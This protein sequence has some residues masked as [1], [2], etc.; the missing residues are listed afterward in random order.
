MCYSKNKNRLRCAMTLTEMIIAMA[1]IVVI[2]TAL[3]PQIRSIQNSWSSKRGNAETIQTARV[4]IDHFSYNLAKAKQ[5]TSVSASTEMNGHIEFIDNNDITMRYDIDNSYVRFGQTDDLYEIAGPV[6][7]LVFTCYAMDDLDNAITEVNDIRVVSIQTT[8]TNS[9]A[10]GEDKTFTSSAYLRTNWNSQLQGLQGWYTLDETS[11]TDAADFSGK[12]NSGTLRNFDGNKWTEGFKNGGLEFDGINDYIESSIPAETITDLSMCCWFKS[13]DAG[14]IGNNYLAQRFISQPRNSIYSR[15]AFGINSNKVGA[16][17]F[18]GWHQVGEG[19][20]TLSPN[21]WYH[22]ALTYDGTYIRIYL[23]GEEENSFYETNLRDGASYGFQIGRQISGERCFHGVLDDVRIYNRVLSAAEIAA[24]AEKGNA[25]E[26]QGFSEAKADSDATSITIQTPGGGAVAKI[27]SWTSELTHQA[28][29]GSNRALILTAH[30]EDNDADMSLNSVTYGGQSMTKIV[31]RETQESSN[32]AYVV[33]YIL[34]EEGINNATGDTF[35]PSWSSNPD[36]VGYSSVFLQNVNQDDLTGSSAG[37]GSNSSSTV[38][39]SSLSTD[40]GDM[41]IVAG[42]AGNTGNYSVNNGFTEEIELS[43]SS[44]DGV[45]GY[46]TADGSSETPSITHSNPYR[47]VIIGFVVQSNQGASPT[48]GNLLIAAVTTDG[49]T[50]SSLSSPSGEGW[51]E[52]EI[53]HKSNA[54]TLGA[55]YKFA[56]A[57]ESASHEFT[58]SGAQQAYGW[59][60]EFTGSDPDTPVNIWSA[61]DDVSSTPTSPAVSTTV[62]NCIILRLGGFDDSNITIDD[63]GL[64][65]HTPITMDSSSTSSSSLVSFE[66]FTEAKRTSN[67]TSLTISK[68]AGTSETD[69]L[70]AAVVT[71]GD[72]KSSLSPPSGQDWTKISLQKKGTKVTLGLW[73]K[74][75]NASEPSSHQFTW[76]GSQEA[77]GWIMRFTGHDTENPINTWAHNGGNSSSASCPSVTTTVANTMIVRIGG[78]DDDDINIDNTGLSSHIDIT[79]DESSSG[80]GTCSGGAGYKTQTSVGSSGTASFSLTNSEQYRTVTVAIAPLTV[81]GEAVSGGAGYITQSSAG[82]SGTSNFSLG[83]SNEAQMFTIAIAP[84][85]SDTADDGIY[86]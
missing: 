6:S 73:W 64:T 2:F 29:S 71:D 46:K 69:L 42:T 82:D 53:E 26:Y 5:I 21:V 47:Q 85:P 59:M 61:D 38:T 56:E 67:G 62:S 55:W 75:A 74:L 63:P 22:A 11:G 30:V 81:G 14:S 86:P 60:M 72:T 77:Y 19:T 70:L 36:K 83:S 66:E 23:D 33:A 57:S 9:A 51:S 28:E 15:I 48:E 76:S 37:N 31:E 18:D 1:I 25:V 80:S 32:R 4:L 45:A 78:F 65:S 54:V 79:M 52:I 20:T 7:Q 34:D 10:M 12:G 50:K 13:F 27:G 49:N 35:S 16:F 24:L 41:V 17:W 40:E 8:V 44:T 68:P 84:V 3:A 58:W 39:T 43:I